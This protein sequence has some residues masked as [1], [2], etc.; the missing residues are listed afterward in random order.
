MISD[1]AGQYLVEIAK[2]AIEHYIETKEKL[3]L[4][5]YYGRDYP[6]YWNPHQ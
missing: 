5:G 1:R 6:G 4:I 3:E 2:E